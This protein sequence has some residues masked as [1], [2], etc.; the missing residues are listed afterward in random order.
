MVPFHADGETMTGPKPAIDVHRLH[1]FLRSRRSVRRFQPAPVDREIVNRIL[2]SAVRA[3]SAHN[4]QP[5]RLAILMDGEAK[6]RLGTA[7]GEEFLQDLLADG[8][9]PH[10]A[11]T[12]VERSR[13]RIREAPVSVLLCMDLTDMDGYPDPERQKAEET[14][15]IQ[16][17]A[18]AGGTLLLAAHAEG[19]GGVWMCAPLF[20]G[21]AARNA[22]DLPDAWIPQGL[23]LL[24]YPA[25]A[26]NPRSRRAL[27]EVARFYG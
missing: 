22:L 16:S 7:M 12:M 15:A 17:V 26:P 8:I 2:R 24:G 14:M 6:S 21:E 3:P 9:V 1:G 25:D 10:E 18:L 19:L 11:E 4:R 13:A 20:A 23:L 27:E 5:W